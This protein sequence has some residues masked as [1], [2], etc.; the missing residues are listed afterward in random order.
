MTQK[1]LFDSLIEAVKE[2]SIYDWISNHYHLMDTYTLTRVFLDIYFHAKYPSNTE[3]NDLIGD[4]V[5][6]CSFYDDPDY[7]EYL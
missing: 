6:T 7:E 1:E 3:P 2:D 4:L 5:M